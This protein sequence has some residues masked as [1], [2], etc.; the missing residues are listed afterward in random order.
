[1]DMAFTLEESEIKNQVG[2]FVKKDLLPVYR[3][4]DEKG[5]LLDD[6]KEKFQLLNL[7]KIYFPEEYGGVGGTFV[8]LTIALKE[9]G[10]GSII[11]VTLLTGNSLVAW[12]LYNYGSDFLKTTYIPDLLS[13]K[14]PAGIAF[15]ES[16]TGSDPKQLKTVAKKSNGGWLLNGSKRFITNSGTGG[17]LMLFALTDEGVTAFWINTKNK[18]YNVGK[19]ESFIH[20]GPL[21]NGELYLDDYFVPDDHVIG[22]VNKGF[23]ILVRAEAIGKIGFCAGY[24]G[25]AERALDLAVGY[26]NTRTHRGKPIGLKFQMTQVKLARMTTRVA[27]MNSYLY[28]VAA[29]VDQG[30]NFVPD[31]ARLKLLV[32]EDVKEIT[33]DAMEIHGAYGLSDEYEIGALFKAGIGVQVIMGASDIQRV[34]IANDILAKGGYDTK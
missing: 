21:D 28:Q 23:E 31:A 20:C 11:P 12:S 33:A 27:A 1:M 32:A 8:G 30:K 24:A 16:D 25:L 13:L 18:G 14:M 22:Q 9:L 10:Y 19:R 34:I 6:V 15:T 2:K 26:A 29:K 4:V 17:Y 7:L 3:E 5:D